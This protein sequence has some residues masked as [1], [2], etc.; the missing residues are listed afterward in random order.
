MMS[1]VAWGCTESVRPPTQPETVSVPVQFES[2][3]HPG[4]PHN[5]RT[6]LTGAEE[7]PAN[8]SQA[9]GQAIFQISEDGMT[10]SYKLIVANIENVTQAH[11]HLAPTGVN[12]AVV[13]WLYPA[14]APP[15]L[16]PGRTDGILAEGVITEASLVG[17]LAGAEL[18]VLIEEMQAG[19]TYVNVH[20]SQYPGG[21]V[22]GQIR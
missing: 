5:H 18:S 7:V 14:A 19:N 3:M 4:S 16:I 10:L 8:D 15:Q 13:A 6:H 12:G 22:R 20:T 17:S 11:I 21:E 9:T 1:A 2:A